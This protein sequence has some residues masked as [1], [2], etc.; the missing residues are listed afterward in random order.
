MADEQLRG[1]VADEKVGDNKDDNPTLEPG[2]Y[3]VEVVGIEYKTSLPWQSKNG[4]TTG[5]EIKFKFLDIGGQK[6]PWDT[7]KQTYEWDKNK[8]IGLKSNLYKALTAI[9]GEELPKDIIFSSFI[10]KKCIVDII[11]KVSPKNGK[12]YSN[13]KDVKRMRKTSTTTNTATTVS[14][15]PVIKQ[16]QVQTT[17][18]Q[19]AKEEVKKVETVVNKNPAKDDFDF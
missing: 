15:D 17:T 13:V 6:Y 14:S 7:T 9:N 5:L 11:N 4:I 19:S 3:D 18:Q 8:S 16:N 12:T 1:R 2:L 10:G